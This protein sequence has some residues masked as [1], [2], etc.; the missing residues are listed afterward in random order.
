L[1]DENMNAQRMAKFAIPIRLM[2]RQDQ[3]TVR[4][5]LLNLMGVNRAIDV[6]WRD[7]CRL[8]ARALGVVSEILG[9]DSAAPSS[10]HG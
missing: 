9:A 10:A 5:R 7:T 3:S 1:A 4:E 2:V 6:I 8:L